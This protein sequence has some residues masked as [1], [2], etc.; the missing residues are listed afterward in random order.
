MKIRLGFVSNS[1]SSSFVCDV[2][3]RVESVWDMCIRDAVM[4]ECENGH[5]IGEEHIVSLIDD[6]IKNDG[7]DKV[8]DMVFAF[9]KIDDEYEKETLHFSNGNEFIRNVVDE[10]DDARYSLP[11]QFCP[12]CSLCHI[13]ADNTLAYLL[14]KNGLS[15][16]KL[17]DEIRTKFSSLKK[18]QEWLKE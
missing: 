3:G 2:S 14:K 6:V 10:V 8:N 15:L 12:I 18:L 4:C 7:V 5:C 11:A 16:T 17:Q 9:Y 1:S 13:S